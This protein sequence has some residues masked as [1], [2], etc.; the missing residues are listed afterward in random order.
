VDFRESCSSLRCHVSWFRPVGFIKTGAK[1]SPSQRLVKNTHL[2]W[3]H[4]GSTA[5]R[6]KSLKLF[7]QRS[8]IEKVK[9]WKHADVWDVNIIES[10]CPE[11]EFRC[12]AHCTARNWVES[13][14]KASL[15]RVL[16]STE[17]A[18][19]LPSFRLSLNFNVRGRRRKKTAQ[20][21]IASR[22]R[23][24]FAALYVCCGKTASADRVST[25]K[26]IQAALSYPDHITQDC[27]F[28]QV[29]FA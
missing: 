24:R 8:R 13:T 16:M 19:Q 4:K 6:L 3:R 23:T 27:L 28:Y 15:C 18:H 9:F 5:R 10:R 12:G 22:A 1:P 29:Y 7:Q 11:A 20:A 14:D 2:V 17:R 21:K 25:R 26:R